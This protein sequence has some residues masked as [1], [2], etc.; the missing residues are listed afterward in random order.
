MS[1][2]KQGGDLFDMAKDGTKSMSK[3]PFQKHIRN[4]NIPVPGDA[5]KQ[6]TIPSVPNPSQKDL[7]DIGS[8]TLH[9]AADNALPEE[10]KPT[11][12]GEIFSATGHEIPNSVAGKPGGRGG[13]L[14]SEDIRRATGGFVSKD[15][16]SKED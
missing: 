13:T 11:G 3:L 15:G 10:G 8:T 5:G 16:R 9:G 14:G 7:G 1:D 2:P 4:P 6:N 12:V